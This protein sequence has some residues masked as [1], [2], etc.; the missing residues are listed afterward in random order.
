M[1]H[2]S[3]F[4][5]NPY[6]YVLYLREDRRIVLR[7]SCGGDEKGALFLEGGKRTRRNERPYRIAISPEELQSAGLERYATS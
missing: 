3:I 6:W 7:G 5:V 2:K 1:L 4:W